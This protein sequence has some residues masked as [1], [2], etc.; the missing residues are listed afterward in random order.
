[1]LGNL[2]DDELIAVLASRLRVRSV[3]TPPKN[4]DIDETELAPI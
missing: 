1:M 4:R 3:D 2:T